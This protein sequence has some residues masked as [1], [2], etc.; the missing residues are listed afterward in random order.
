MD[1]GPRDTTG[2]ER[3][4]EPPVT[5]VAEMPAINGMLDA[6]KAG[7]PVR[8]F[9]HTHRQDPANPTVPLSYRLAYNAHGLYVLVQVEAECFTCRDRGY[10]HGD[11]L[12]LVLASARP[13]GAPS[14]EYSLLGFWP[15]DDPHE[16]VGQFV[17]AY[18]G[19]FPFRVLD[20]A[21]QF[22]VQP[23]E[24][25]VNFELLLPW[26]EVVPHHPWLSEGIGFD[27]FFTQAVGEVQTNLYSVVL[28]DLDAWSIEAVAY[29]RLAFDEATLERGAQTYLMLDRHGHQGA[30]LRARSATWA[31]EPTS[32]TL[33]LRV[34]AGEGEVLEGREI[35]YRCKAGLT[36]QRHEFATADLPPGGYRVQWRSRK[37]ASRGVTG[38]SVLP[39]FDLDTETQRLEAARGTVPDGT[40]TTLQFQLQDLGSQLARLRPHETCPHLRTEL[41]RY[42]A[43]ADRVER[44]VDVL[45]GKTGFLRRA[46]RSDIDGTL[47]PYTVRIP[48]SYDPTRPYPYP[49]L[50]FLHG[51]DR[52]DRAASTHRAHLGPDD[53]FIVAPFGRGMTN[54]FTQDHAQ[55]DIQEAIEDATRHYAL[56]M[57]R[58][59][60]A[61]FSMGGY[62][63]YRTYYEAPERFKAMAVFSGS[64]SL[65][66]RY[67]PGEEHPDFLQ[68]AYVRPF[69]GVPVFVFHGSEDRNAPFELA[70]QTV[71]KLQ[72]AGADVK[73]YVQQGAGHVAPDEVAR[74]AYFA[75]L[76]RVLAE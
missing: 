3:V 35:A 42:L 55:K 39:A 38:L 10:Q 37:H 69:A 36:V 46:F 19:G 30:V 73:F 53:L 56:D 22:V 72:A 14:D 68:E 23:H 29:T 63:V 40:L 43:L 47:Q 31:S 62:G 7:L 17:W 41:E 60:L 28:H 25:Q 48:Q 12:L 24:G 75:W 11:G 13:E 49:V 57:G 4:L 2:G 76:N 54:C 71:E 61:G 67:Y 9:K 27:L 58:V 33:A 44:G 65:P 1:A 74:E 26:H 32:E 45:A 59:A 51:S 6:V 15:K 52:D 8:T 5:F 64:P 50:V 18:N 66:E 34:L 21:T 16:R 20:E 70:E